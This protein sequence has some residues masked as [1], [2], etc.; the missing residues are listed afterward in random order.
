MQKYECTEL[1]GEGAYGKVMKATNREDGDV[2]AIKQIKRAFHS[3][4]E[5]MRL[6]ELQ[7]LRKLKHENIVRLKELIRDSAQLFFVFE[8]IPTNLASL[9]S[10][11][12]RAGTPFSTKEVRDISR[13]LFAGMAYMHKHNYFHRDIKP[14]N[15]LVD[16]GEWGSGMLATLWQWRRRRARGGGWVGDYYTR[17]FTAK[18]SQRCTELRGGREGAES[19][20]SLWQSKGVARWVGMEGSVRQYSGCHYS[21]SVCV[22]MAVC[23]AEVVMVFVMAMVGCSLCR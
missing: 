19:G 16:P 18:G 11:R 6:R 17:L 15:L 12:R 5:C 2:V 8:Y 10:E 9:T 23:K 22:R 4:E 21:P 3:W 20:A 14:D 13:Q 1:L 7:A